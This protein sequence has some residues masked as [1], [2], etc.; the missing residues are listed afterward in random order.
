M[1]LPLTPPIRIQPMEERS[2]SLKTTEKL[3]DAFLDDFHARTSAVQGG[4]T[5]VSVQLQKLK[6]ALAQ[7]NSGRYK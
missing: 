1:D 6:D 4:N 2:V 5:S 7:E 3:L